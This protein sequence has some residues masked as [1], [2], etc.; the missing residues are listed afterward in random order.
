MVETI[1]T[2]IIN[3]EIPANIIYEDENTLAFLDIFPFEKGH[4]LVIPKKSYERITDMPEDE[5]INLQKVVLKISKNNKEKLK[6]NVGT[7]VFG[8][9]VPH[10]HVHIFPITKDLDVF[11]FSMNK[12]AKYLGNEAQNYKNVL[13]LD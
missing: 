12:R 6:K 4:T 1:F 13:K 5:Y 11:N 10:V 7:L 9:E 8:E 2:K 3:R